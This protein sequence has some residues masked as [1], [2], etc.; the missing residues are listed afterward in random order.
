MGD[1]HGG[2]F[3][4]STQGEEAGRS[5]WAPGHPGLQ[6]YRPARVN[7]ITKKQEKGPANHTSSKES[8]PRIQRPSSV[9]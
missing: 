6:S 2:T 9:Q 8:I 3:N 1:G 7:K 5:L 4:C